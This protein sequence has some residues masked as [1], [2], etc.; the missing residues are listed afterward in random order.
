M[1]ATG[2]VALHNEWHANRTIRHEED[3]DD[4]TMC[5]CGSPMDA[6]PGI[7]GAGTDRTIGASEDEEP[8]CCGAGEWVYSPTCSAP[9][10]TTLEEHADRTIGSPDLVRDALRD[11]LA[12]FEGAYAN[13]LATSPEHAKNPGDS[14]HVETANV[15]EPHVADISSGQM[16]VSAYTPT[17]DEH[18]A[19]VHVL[20]D[21]VPEDW[22]E[23]DIGI[24]ADAVLAAGFHSTVQGDS[25]DLRVAESPVQGEPSDVQELLAEADALVESWDRKGSW[26]S[27]SPVGLV[28]RLARALRAA[29][30]TVGER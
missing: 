23:N 18:A 29:A 28:M 15:S 17:D 5:V 24:L 14:L 21:Q 25:K 19:L 6:C 22:D 16:S 4:Y 27:D 20:W 26:S 1:T 10:W 8:N 7:D 12:V 9:K 2:E 30:E 3:V 11:A 13:D